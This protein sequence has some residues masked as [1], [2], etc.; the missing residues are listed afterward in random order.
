MLY[1]LIYW[2]Y[3]VLVFRRHGSGRCNL[4]GKRCLYPR[5]EIQEIKDFE[6]VEFPDVPDD[7]VNFCHCSIAYV[8][9]GKRL[10]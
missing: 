3:E 4:G 8:I 2:N 5:R 9:V 7:V 1:L 10:E 6:P